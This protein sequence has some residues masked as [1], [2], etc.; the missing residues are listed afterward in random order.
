MG[1]IVSLQDSSEFCFTM[2][3]YDLE[4]ELMIA[5]GKDKRKE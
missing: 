3:L 4:N 1:G 5:R 2:W